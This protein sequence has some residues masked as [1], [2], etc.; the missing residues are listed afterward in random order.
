[1]TPRGVLTR[2]PESDPEK[3][4]DYID[5]SEDL[6]S[7]TLIKTVTC[8]S[9]LNVAVEYPYDCTFIVLIRATIE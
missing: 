9:F 7:T 4:M 8:Y 2:I 6:L 3:G 1:M 5:F